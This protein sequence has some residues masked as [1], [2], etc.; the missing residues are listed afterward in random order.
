MWLF[1]AG[2]GKPSHQ[3]AD[4]GC[5]SRESKGLEQRLLVRLREQRG[6]LGLS[7]RV[8]TRWEVESRR[9]IVG[10]FPCVPSALGGLR[11]R[12]PR[13]RC[14]CCVKRRLRREGQEP[15]EL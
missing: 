5:S 15:G 14:G 7:T 8:K 2:L 11:G 3:D 12:E 9:P 10:A 13:R 6:A 4:W 1:L